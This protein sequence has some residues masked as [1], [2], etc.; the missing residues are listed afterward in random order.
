MQNLSEDWTVQSPDGDYEV[1]FNF[2]HYTDVSYCEDHIPENFPH[3]SPKPSKEDPL[4]SRS[5]GP[6]TSNYPTQEIVEGISRPNPVDIRE[7]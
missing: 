3:L 6:L 7:S 2:C 5:C 1:F 4:E